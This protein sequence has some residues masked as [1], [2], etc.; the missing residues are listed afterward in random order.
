METQWDKLYEH[1]TWSLEGSLN[2][3]IEMLLC[4]VFKHLESLDLIS[5]FH[6]CI[7]C[8]HLPP[9]SGLLFVS[10]FWGQGQAVHFCSLRTVIDNKSP[11]YESYTKAFLLL[12]LVFFFFF[13][14]IIR[15]KTWK[16]V[17]F[18]TSMSFQCHLHS[19]QDC[20][21]PASLLNR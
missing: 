11:M 6:T 1:S 20:E 12:L 13:Q 10:V 9:Y 14:K 7:C 5:K 3:Y 4:S 19:E 16:T 17:Y 21:E 18:R 8:Q 2:Y 15:T